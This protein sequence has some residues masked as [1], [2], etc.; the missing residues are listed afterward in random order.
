M[1]CWI[2]DCVNLCKV[3]SNSMIPVIDNKM[4]GIYEK[5]ISHE[6]VVGQLV[7]KLIAVQNVARK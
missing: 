6:N 5:N 3:H 7:I 2:N 1:E 4:M